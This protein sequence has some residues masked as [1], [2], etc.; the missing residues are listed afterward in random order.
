MK[1]R[2]KTFGGLE[3]FV[4]LTD[5][6]KILQTDSKRTINISNTLKSVPDT[7]KNIEQG[8]K[9]GSYIKCV[10]LE[11]YLSNRRNIS[12]DFKMKIIDYVSSEIKIFKGCSLESMF[13]DYLES[14]LKEMIPTLVLERQKTIDFKVFDF[15]INNKLIIEFD[16][17]HHKYTKPND[18]EKDLI[19]ENKKYHLIR[20][21]SYDSYGKSTALIYKQCKLL[22]L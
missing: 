11:Q 12:L 3:P 14:F 13:I 2:I 6:N 16:E 22:F 20:V 18:E 8:A 4:S 5:I 10:Y 21:K 9:K 1:I 19:L 15:C 7:Y 17:S